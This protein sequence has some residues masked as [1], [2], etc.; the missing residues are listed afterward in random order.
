M[1]ISLKKIHEYDKKINDYIDEK[2]RA[3]IKKYPKALPLSFIVNGVVNLGVAVGYL[4]DG[5]KDNSH[6]SDYAACSSAASGLALL[7][8]GIYELKEL[9]KYS[10]HQENKNG[11]E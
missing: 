6:L 7:S 2:V 4:T 5:H 10:A 1:K 3:Y 8:F 11:D 9:R